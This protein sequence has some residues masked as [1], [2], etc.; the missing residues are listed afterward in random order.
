[1]EPQVLFNAAI[2]IICLLGGAM[3]R[4]IYDAVKELRH[5]DG[6]IHDRINAMPSIYMRRDDFVS[7]GSRIEATLIRIESKLDGKADK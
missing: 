2:G 1:M 3:L 4:S 5:S 6:E 7:F